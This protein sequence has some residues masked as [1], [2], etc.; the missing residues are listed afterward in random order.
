MDRLFYWLT[1]GAAILVLLLLL[2][3]ALSMLLG[4][5]LAL[6]T[7]GWGFLT[8]TVWN[9]VTQQFSAFVPIYGTIVTSVIALL[10]AVPVSFGIAIFLSEI[11]PT[12]MRRPIS[13]A[14]EL[15]AGIPSIIYGMWGLFFFAPLMA[16]SVEPALKSYL[17]PLPLIGSLFQGPPLGIGI[18]TAGIILAIMIVPFI[19]SVVRD[20][21]LMLPA[22]LK[23]SAY[24]LGSTKWEL[25]RSI[26]I[27][28]ARSAIVGGIFLGL[29]R[30]LGETMAV[31]FVL[32]NA[33]ELSR[34][35]L[36]PGNSIAATLANEFTEADSPMYLSALIA[37]GFLL[38]IV[39]FIVL[40]LA[41]LLLL[42]MDKKEGH[43]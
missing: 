22:S 2:S 34:S 29:G 16:S 6:K 20:V 27:P 32:G 37:L 42:R 5:R 41:K 18:L 1:A 31:T 9:P 23:E 3:A 15:L 24:A 28:Y 21:F 8:G 36:M 39:T 26:V 40:A 25:I 38:F 4:G 13:S 19:S 30:A 12:W 11:A 7:F 35:L 33:H 43:F 10:I 17:G 14:I